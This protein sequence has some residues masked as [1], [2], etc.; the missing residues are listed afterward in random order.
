MITNILRAPSEIVGRQLTSVVF[1]LDYL[2]FIFD[3]PCL[4]ALTRP[5]F[6]KDDEVISSGPGYCDALCSQ[7]GVPVRSVGVQENHLTIAFVSGAQIKVSLCEG[8]YTGPEAINYIGESRNWL[9]V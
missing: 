9:V 7:I 3:G 8:D 2:Q 5:T 6:H 1:I 4:P